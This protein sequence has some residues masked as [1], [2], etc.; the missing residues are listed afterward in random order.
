MAL[1]STMQGF[2]E[3]RKTFHFTVE[4]PYSA[5]EPTLCGLKSSYVQQYFGLTTADMTAALE[6]KNMNI[7]AVWI[8]TYTKKETFGATYTAEPFGH[9]FTNAGV[10]TNKEKNYA[11]CITY[12]YPDFVLTHNTS[13]TTEG[14]TYTLREAIIKPSTK[15]TLVYEFSVTLGSRTSVQTDQPSL[16]NS[17]KS[18]TD[19][20]IVKP[21]VRQNDGR[22]MNQ[23][24]IQVNI[25]DKITL[26]ADF[27]PSVYKSGKYKFAKE[28]WDNTKKA[29]V[30]KN[31]SSYSA[32]D[33]VLTEKAK[34]SDSG[35][36][37]ITV[38]LTKQTGG[39]STK[40]YYYYVDVQENAGKFFDWRKNTPELS[41]NFRDE[42]PTLE[43]PQKV[44]IFD[45]W[46]GKRANMY[47][48]EWWTAYWGDDLNAECGTDSAT[49]YGAAKNMVDF[50]DSEYHYIRDV[51]G[52]PPDLSA[53]SG[54]KSIIYTFG[55][56]L[57]QDT[58][59][60]WVAG[61]YQGWVW[62]ANDNA[63]W[64]CVWSSFY[65]FSR[66]RSDAYQLWNDVD[67]QRGAMIHEGIHAL[68]AD[69][70]GAKWSAWFQEAG[71]TWLQTTMAAKRSGIYGYPGFLDGCPFVAPF[72]PIECYSGWLQD[73][74]FGGPTAEGVNMYDANGAQICTWRNLLGGTQYGNSF[75]I[76]FA[77]MCGEG[78]IPW[79]WRYC[80]GRVLEGIGDYL[81]DDPM[82]NIILQ[83]RARQALFDI[84]NWAWGYRAVTCDNMGTVIRAEW[85]PYWIDVAPYAL[86]PY[87]TMSINDEDGARG[88]LAPD[89]LTNPGWS[90]ANIIPI[91]TSGNVCEVEFRPEDSEMRAQLCYRTKDGKCYYSQPVQCGTLS[92]NLSQQPANGV[93]FCVV[94]NTDYVYMGEEQRK[95]H[96]DYRIKLGQGALACADPYQKWSLYEE[97][98]VDWGFVTGISDVKND[99]SVSD[100]EGN[101]KVRIMSGML[102]AG[103][104][105][106]LS[107]GRISVQDVNV[108]MV[109]MSGVVVA[110]GR[111]NSNGTYTIPANVRPGFYGITFSHGNQRDSYKV[112]L[113]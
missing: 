20:W 37:I 30:T 94:A 23:N 63:G 32:E 57:N 70:P 72:M 15:D 65:P 1:L 39:V 13:N 100:G 8:G 53:R 12:R 22:R 108:R 29:R 49:V 96:W 95:H 42:Y 10:S 103:N 3:G 35:R 36:Y 66:F 55:S 41:Y 99:A 62:C 61:G 80:G 77:E 67:Y 4:R 87:A 88:W 11:L 75:P 34:K 79:I 73:G 82:R 46:N 17:R 109:G 56:G 14:E 27:D 93:V 44:H 25:G 111:L 51:M 102:R 47:V 98:I 113:K 69:L 84:G 5:T 16:V 107:L 9:W 45:Q 21:M 97:N 92:I 50:F 71:N 24:Y 28:Y 81:G 76:V 31:L 68:L 78:S 33:F 43:T 7:Q 26:G 38:F 112:I 54:Y 19:D 40:T 104:D 89:T 85:A 59:A 60:P 64:N 74:S 91:H 101:D 6:S 52:W 90:G 58:E 110:N 86:T 2:A 106:Q 83:Y 48:G 105:V 18:Y